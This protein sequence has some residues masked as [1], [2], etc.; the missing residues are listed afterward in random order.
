[1]AIGAQDAD[2]YDHRPFIIMKLPQAIGGGILRAWEN[3]REPESVRS[4]ADAYW[5]GLLFVTAAVVV[6][7]VVFGGSQFLIALEDR[8]AADGGEDAPAVLDSSALSD[9][10][11][12]FREREE[13]HEALKQNPPSAT[14]PSR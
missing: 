7:A 6:A 2:L 1:M 8:K 9:V 12:S 4:L 11:S 5:T 10:L 3:R 13:A 14:D